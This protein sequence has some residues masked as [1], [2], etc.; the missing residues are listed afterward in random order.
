[1]LICYLTSSVSRKFLSN[2]S[3]A[4]ATVPSRRTN[5]FHHSFSDA[6]RLYTPLK[7]RSDHYDSS[8]GAVS[9]A[10]EGQSKNIRLLTVAS[11]TAIEWHAYGCLQTFLNCVYKAQFSCISDI[12]IVAQHSCTKW[13][14]IGRTNSR[15]EV[16][17]RLNHDIRWV[18]LVELGQ[19]S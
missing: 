10:V 17:I 18:C 15:L 9:C 11:Y 1:M 8:L 7:L 16:W 19:K 2:T 4:A 12:V 3:A 5:L 14:P 6:G 13:T